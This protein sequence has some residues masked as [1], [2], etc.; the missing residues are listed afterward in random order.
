MAPPYSVKRLGGTEAIHAV[1]DMVQARDFDRKMLLLATQ[2]A[3]DANLK[4]L[5]LTV[6]DSLLTFLRF[7]AGFDH[8]TEALA[9]IR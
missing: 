2:L 9:M 6:L 3:H 5:L 8:D 4:L 7:Q 1:R